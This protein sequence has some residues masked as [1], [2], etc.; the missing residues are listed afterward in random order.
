LAWTH[1]A[2]L[3]FL[4]SSVKV[5]RHTKHEFAC[6]RLWKSKG[7]CRRVVFKTC[8]AALND[9]CVIAVQAKG[10]PASIFFLYNWKQTFQVFDWLL[11][12]NKTFFNLT[13]CLTT[14]ITLVMFLD[15]TAPQ[16][17][18]NAL[19]K[20]ISDLEERVQKR[21]L[22]NAEIAGLRETVRVLAGLVGIPAERSKRVSQ[23]LALVDS[24]TP[25]LTDAIRSL[26]TRVYPK[27]LEATEVRNRL[28]D[29]GFNFGDFSNPLSACHAALK[30]LVGDEL[31]S[32]GKSKDGKTTYC[33][34]LKVQRGALAE[35]IAGFAGLSQPGT[36]FTS[37]SSLGA[38][39]PDST[40][41]P[42]MRR[43]MAR[44]E[45]T[46]GEQMRDLNAIRKQFEKK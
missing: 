28:E 1:R 17:Y 3:R 33:A 24:A 31:A 6:G 7:R 44:K 29:S 20:A 32:T 42:E 13:F 22:L 19:D 15:M 5:V 36:G 16:E 41:S 39:V 8:V 34:V 40:I 18:V 35:A 25:N 43:A 9:G 23:L 38:P 2:S 30:R 4:V 10:S 27:E 45:K 21:D 26:L 11:M 14:F 12:S 37:L 46:P